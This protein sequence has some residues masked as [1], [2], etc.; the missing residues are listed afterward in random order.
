MSMGDT[1]AVPTIGARV[2]I[3]PAVRAD[4]ASV[5]TDFNTFFAGA[6]LWMVAIY[7]AGVA[8]GYFATVWGHPDRAGSIGA[9]LGLVAYFMGGTAV[10]VGWHRHVLFGEAVTTASTL[11]FGRRELHFCLFSIPLGAVMLAIGYLLGLAIPYVAGF[12]SGTAVSTPPWIALGALA[13][14]MLLF[15][16]EIRMS[17]F[18]PLA[19]ADMR[20]NLLLRSWW[21]SA[22]NGWRIFGGVSLVVLIFAIP[23]VAATVMLAIAMNQGGGFFTFSLFSL[24]GNLINLAFIAVMAGF[25]SHAAAQIAGRTLPLGAADALALARTP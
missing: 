3:W 19:A 12:F 22:G 23:R 5:F 6:W 4:L 8:G 17:L 9:I 1:G 13:L 24:L 21:L 20:G 15:V 18:A 14:A 10:A 2:R 25:L 16:A 7:A 11:R